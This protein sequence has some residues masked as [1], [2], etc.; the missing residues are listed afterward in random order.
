MQ[1][2]NTTPEHV[3]ANGKP[4][5]NLMALLSFY[6]RRTEMLSSALLKS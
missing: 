3:Y 5:Y 1:A 6:K 2:M 4:L